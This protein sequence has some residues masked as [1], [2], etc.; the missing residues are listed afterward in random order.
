MNLFSILSIYHLIFLTVTQRLILRA[1][2]IKVCLYEILEI[3]IL[4]NNIVL[5]TVH[6][7]QLVSYNLHFKA[8]EVDSKKSIIAKSLINIEQFSGPPI[9]IHQI[10]DGKLMIRLKEYN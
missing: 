7:I 2:I 1:Q 4:Q 6:Q 5:F 8:Y 3:I 9:N 10:P